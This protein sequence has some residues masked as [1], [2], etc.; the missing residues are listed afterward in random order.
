MPPISV[1]I[2]CANAASTLEAACLSVAWA[3]E[4]VV[5]DA[6]SVDGTEAI[7]RR[8][9]HRY[10]HEPWRGFTGQFALAVSLASHPWVLR[11][12]ADEECTPELAA[13]LRAIPPATLDATDIFRIRM[14][15]F[16]FGRVVRSWEPDWKARFHHRDRISWVPDAVH[17]GP[18]S[19]GGRPERR[20][21]GYLLH[22]RASPAGFLDYFNGEL[23]D[24]RLR[25]VIEDMQARG[26][27][28]HW[29]DVAL[30]PWATFV[31]HYVFRRGFLDGMFGLLMAQKAA[32]AV[33]LKYAALWAAERGFPPGD[34]P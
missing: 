18:T 15:H 2:A 26:R 25:L 33:Q 9:A 11:L 22:R 27:R 30:R 3:D 34:R 12:D 28:C 23:T 14:R 7:A 32:H 5:V 31:K 29:H 13:A 8:Y 6:G 16:I 24:T 1:V 21:R 4:L 17:P 10:V 20:V 19:S